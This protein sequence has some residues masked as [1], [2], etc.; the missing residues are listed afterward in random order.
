MVLSHLSL[1][2]R[3]RYSSSTAP[4]TL[5][6]ALA[7]ALRT[8]YEFFS[9]ACQS[10]VHIHDTGADFSATQHCQRICRLFV[11]SSVWRHVAHNKVGLRFLCNIAAWTCSTH[12]V[13]LNNMRQATAWI[14]SPCCVSCMDISNSDLVVRSLWYFHLENVADWNILLLTVCYLMFYNLFVLKMNSLALTSS[15]FTLSYCPYLIHNR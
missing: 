2:S 10:Y 14:F 12:H 6:W 11:N 5:T 13:Y 4:A 1:A 9:N 8:S 7:P 3:Q 15:S